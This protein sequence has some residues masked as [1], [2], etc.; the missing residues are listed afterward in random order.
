MLHGAAIY[1]TQRSLQPPDHRTYSAEVPT[2]TGAISCIIASARTE[3]LLSLRRA[4]LHSNPRSRE[5]Q[6]L[7]R[8]FSKSFCSFLCF[9]PSRRSISS[10]DFHKENPRRK[11]P[12]GIGGNYRTIIHKVAMR[13]PLRHISTV[14]STY[15]KWYPLIIICNVFL[16]FPDTLSRFLFLSPV[17]APVSVGGTI[18][19]AI[20][21]IAV[22][23]P[24]G[25]SVTPI[26]IPTIAAVSLEHSVRQFNSFFFFHKNSPILVLAEFLQREAHSQQIPLHMPRFPFVALLQWERTIFLIDPA[27]PS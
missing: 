24:V 3:A 15:H 4:P 11:H 12:T 20:S 8:I 27:A 26:C 14:V 6:A 2:R 1:A 23:P 13:Q 9:G 5:C 21:S 19:S 22:H 17:V 25:I 18:I 7:F 16:E 10:K